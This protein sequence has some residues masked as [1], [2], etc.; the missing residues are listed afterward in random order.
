MRTFL[1]QSK[2]P[3][4]DVDVPVAKQEIAS[5][6]DRYRQSAI[7]HFKDGI[8]FGRTCHQW[9]VRYKAQGSRSGRGFEHLLQELGIPKTTAYRWIKRYEM[10]YALRADRHEVKEHPGNVD[11]NGAAVIRSVREKVSFVFLLTDDE[12]L[13][14]RQDMKIL[15]GEKKV[16]EMFLQFVTQTAYEKRKMNGANGNGKVGPHREDVRRFGVGA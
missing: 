3:F 6:W 10:K 16:A 14:L 7:K 9:Q 1:P 13:K 12:R 11:N 5:A 15:G 4:Y 8:E 2:L